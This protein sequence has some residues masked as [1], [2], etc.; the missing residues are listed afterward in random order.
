MATDRSQKLQCLE[1]EE[2]RALLIA[3][4]LPWCSAPVQER[5]AEPSLTEQEKDAESGAPSPQGKG[6]GF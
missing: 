5:G 4:R 2:E 6:S 1:Q 3:A